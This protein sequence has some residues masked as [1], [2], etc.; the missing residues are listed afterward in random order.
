M[1]GHAPTTALNEQ[2]S[3]ATHLMNRAYSKSNVEPG[4]LKRCVVYCKQVAGHAPRRAVKRRKEGKGACMAQPGMTIG[5]RQSNWAMAV[6]SNEAGGD[7]GW[8]LIAG[9]R[10]QSRQGSA[11]HGGLLLSKARLH[12]LTWRI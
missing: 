1:I 5:L 8:K 2:H 12:P 4:V 11:Q 7:W 3:E 9:G 6:A 10:H